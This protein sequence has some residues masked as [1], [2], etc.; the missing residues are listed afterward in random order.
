MLGDPLPDTEGH[1][2]LVP[3]AAVARQPGNSD[4]MQ[5]A[6]SQGDAP[7]AVHVTPAS[8]SSFRGGG[9]AGVCTMERPQLA[10]GIGSQILI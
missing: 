3:A 10:S 5:L 8:E 2:I 1:S 7:F 6:Q 4:V 9:V